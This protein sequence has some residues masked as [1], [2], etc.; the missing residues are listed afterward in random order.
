MAAADVHERGELSL[1][2]AAAL[3]SRGPAETQKGLRC[4]LL[5]PSHET[6]ESE[7]PWMAL[8]EAAGATPIAANEDGLRLYALDDPEDCAWEGGDLEPAT[9]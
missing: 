7:A 1:P 5:H 8:M 4:V 2:I 3:A 6:G 9:P